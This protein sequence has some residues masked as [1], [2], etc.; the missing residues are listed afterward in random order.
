ME[1]LSPIAEPPYYLGPFPTL[2][3]RYLT[4]FDTVMKAIVENRWCA[5]NKSLDY[6]L[7][8][9][10]ART[11][12]TA[13]EELGEQGPFYLK[14]GEPKGDHMLLEDDGQITAVIDWE[15]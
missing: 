12:A 4:Y 15:W 10:A 7:A 13:R 9:L 14:H 5:P 1:Y 11:L 8:L 6:Y 2:Q 3:A